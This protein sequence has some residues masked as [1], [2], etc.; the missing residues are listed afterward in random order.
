MSIVM[1]QIELERAR[2]KRESDLAGGARFARE[3]YEFYKS[4]VYG[5]PHANIE[6]L[7]RLKRDAEVADLRLRLLQTAPAAALNGQT[8]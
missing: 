4:E 7:R 1:T 6:R 2:R 5:S 8:K 3:R